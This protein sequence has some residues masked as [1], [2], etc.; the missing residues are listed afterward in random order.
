[1][2]T[3]RAFTILAAIALTAAGVL[4]PVDMA[5][6]TRLSL[7]LSPTPDRRVVTVEVDDRA[8]AVFGRWP[9]PRSLLAQLVARVAEADPAVIGVDIILSEPDPN[10]TGDLL[11]QKRW[12][13]TGEWFFRCTLSHTH[14]RLKL[15]YM[16]HRACRSA[17]FRFL[18]TE[19][20]ESDM[21]L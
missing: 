20:Q 16:P 7:A 18:R 11:W 9:W 12:A 14:F 15:G 19:L 5:V 4:L 3:L 21:S 17:R 1:M 13:I 2:R 6:K 8:L 10:G